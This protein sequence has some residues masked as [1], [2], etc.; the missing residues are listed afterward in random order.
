[1]TTAYDDKTPFI[2]LSP[3]GHYV[4]GCICMPV[5]S[6]VF[7]INS[8]LMNGSL[9]TF[10]CQL[11]SGQRKK[12]VNFGK[13]LAHILNTKKSQILKIGPQSLPYLYPIELQV[14]TRIFKLMQFVWHLAS[15][16]SLYRTSGNVV[17]KF[18]I[19]LLGSHLCSHGNT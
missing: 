1:M 15:L 11:M 10:L 16:M 4:F 3:P 9:C 18:D 2:V 13:D 19:L 5:C 12:S 6:S 14:C 7:A 8:K 17:N